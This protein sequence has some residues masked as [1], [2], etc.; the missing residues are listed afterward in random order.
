MILEITNKILIFHQMNT[1]EII[2]KILDYRIQKENIIL[3]TLPKID[4][5]K[6]SLF[7]DA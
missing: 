3:I 4:D 7:I 6:W 5:I 1:K 2:G